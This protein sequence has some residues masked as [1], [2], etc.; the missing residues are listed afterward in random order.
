M[1]L[2]SGHINSQINELKI[3]GK[4][5]LAVYGS[6]MIHLFEAVR[7]GYDKK[8]FSKM[9]RGPIG[10]IFFLNTYIC[11]YIMNMLKSFIYFMF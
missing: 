10:N 4:N 5:S 1:L 6:K 2:P 7:E 11:M 8:M 9:P 3:R